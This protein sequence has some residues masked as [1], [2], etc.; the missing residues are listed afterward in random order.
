MRNTPGWNLAGL[1][2]ACLVLAG[3]S[4]GK[5][6]RYYHD[7]PAGA[8]P[9]PGSLSSRGPGPGAGGAAD[10]LTR[11]GPGA[12]RGGLAP[13]GTTTSSQ[14]A[15]FGS[16]PAPAGAGGPAPSNPNNWPPPG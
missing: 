2:L 8:S 9:P 6:S 16:S 13:L 7:G 3:C 14:G 5:G 10:P 12:D 4:H 15:S 1:S 11:S